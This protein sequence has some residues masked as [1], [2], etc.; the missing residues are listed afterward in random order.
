MTPA[1]SRLRSVAARIFAPKTM[2][3]LIDP[4]LADVELER[5]EALRCGRLWLARW[6]VFRGYVALI[7]AVAL[8]GVHSFFR[9][10]GAAHIVRSAA[11]A[12]VVLTVALMI[13]P[14]RRAPQVPTFAALA[15]YLIPQAIPLSIPLAVAFG[16][17]RSTSRT[18]LDRTSIRTVLVL[19][20][21]GTIVVLVSMEWLGPAANQAFRSAVAARVAADG[22]MAEIRRGLS[23]RPFSELTLT[24]RYGHA[25]LKQDDH[26]RYPL[27][28][29]ET[30]SS[31][32]EWRFTRSVH[33]LLAL[34]FASA[35]FGLMG[36]ALLGAI[37]H[38]T[39]LRIAL[40]AV[41][42][43]YIAMLFGTSAT[44]PQV[45]AALWAWSPNIAMVLIAAVLFISSRFRPSLH[46]PSTN[47]V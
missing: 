14:L 28:G 8:Q 30:R 4:V 40:M 39:L 3:R 2:E 26:I 33:R 31:E 29:V 37:R 20:L 46:D 47:R 19:A 24:V 1:T 22:R 13:P 32:H 44:R 5:C 27:W 7:R 12:F 21:M 16:I 23:E 6:V 45:P 9:G 41:A 35:V 42:P 43:L 36:A 15:V 38:R 25:A 10:D 11:A 34:P 17:A 18:V